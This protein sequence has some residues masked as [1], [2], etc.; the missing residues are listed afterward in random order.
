MAG[1]KASDKIFFYHVVKV[2]LKTHHPTFCQSVVMP[3]FNRKK[4]NFNLF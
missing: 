2:N 4:V 3:Q 1:F